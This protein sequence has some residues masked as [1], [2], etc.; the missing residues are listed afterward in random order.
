MRAEKKGN[1]PRK[2]FPTLVFP[3]SLSARKF[4]YD[5]KLANLTAILGTIPERT[6][7]R[8]LYKAKGVSRWT[9]MTPVA[10]NPL[11]FVY[12]EY[13]KSEKISIWEEGWKKRRTPGARPDL[14]SCIR[15][16]MVSRG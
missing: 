6:A 2:I 8:P 3:V 15:T 14:E 7:P 11:A 13:T 9:I 12:I 1:E 10:M 4:L 5:S 16:L